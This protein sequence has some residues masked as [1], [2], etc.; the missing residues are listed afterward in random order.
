VTHNTDAHN[1]MHSSVQTGTNATQ[2][3]TRTHTHTHA[4][5][6][7]HVTHAHIN[8]HM[9]THPL[10]NTQTHA[11]THARTH[12]QHTCTLT[13]VH[14]L[15]PNYVHSSS[16]KPM[17]R[18]PQA[19]HPQPHHQQ[20]SH[21]IQQL[22]LLKL[23][24]H[25]GLRVWGRR[26]HSWVMSWQRTRA[27]KRYVYVMCGLCVSVIVFVSVCVA[28][29]A[30]VCSYT[31]THTYVCGHA[32]RHTQMRALILPLMHAN[33]CTRTHLYTHMDAQTFIRTFITVCTH[34]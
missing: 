2:S 30:R 19:V 25:R 16:R 31:H 22:C 21:T 14:T 3:H 12:T 13:H 24:K 32:C 7:T 5:I 18:L 20:D 15:T 33:G 11:R 23:S 27:G 34:A 1:Y 9:S 8:S 29:L 6:Y 17:K 26:T 10:L 4:H 28:A